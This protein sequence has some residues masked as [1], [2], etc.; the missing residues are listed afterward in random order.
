MTEN[1]PN[2]QFIDMNNVGEFVELPEIVY[3]KLRTGKLLYAHFSDIVRNSLLAKYGGLWLDATVYTSGKIPEI[4]KSYTFFSP[5]DEKNASYW[6]TYAMGSNKINSITF[7]FL[8]EM[9]IA[10]CTR[11][12]VWPEYLLQDRLISFAYRNIISS[13]I[14]IDETPENN[15]RRFMLFAL[16]NKPYN[17]DIYNDLIKDNFIFKLSYKAKYKLECD[18]KQTY[19]A[20]LIANKQ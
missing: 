2:V 3:K 7:C 1:N 11:E 17:D 9:L 5:N 16:M 4:A 19:Y 20:K 14:A 6:C 8:K 15:T 10:V 13:K 18:G 12:D